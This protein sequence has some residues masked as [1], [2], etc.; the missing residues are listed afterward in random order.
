MLS[1]LPTPAPNSMKGEQDA[2]NGSTVE[3]EAIA[4]NS[5]PTGTHTK[6]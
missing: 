5:K 4:Q 1:G 3:H 2:F 6:G